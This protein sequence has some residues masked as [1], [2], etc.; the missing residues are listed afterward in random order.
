[1]HDEDVIAGVDR[2]ANGRT[3]HPVVRERLR[4]HAID[5]ID[6]GFRAATL[7]R[8]RHRLQC[9]LGDPQHDNDCRDGGADVELPRP[10][11]SASWKAS[12]VENVGLDY[13]R[14]RSKANKLAIR[15][16]FARLSPC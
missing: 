12:R 3:E 13:L 16:V 11:H 8:A 6:A 9:V 5:F 2:E 15:R 4:P 14:A 10:F 1:M 7:L